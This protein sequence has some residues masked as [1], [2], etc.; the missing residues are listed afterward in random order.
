MVEG[1]DDTVQ[2]AEEHGKGLD[3]REGDMEQ[4]EHDEHDFAFSMNDILKSIKQIYLNWD[5]LIKKKN[6]HEVRYTKKTLS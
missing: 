6:T 3:A 2:G 4:R 5:D 1:Q